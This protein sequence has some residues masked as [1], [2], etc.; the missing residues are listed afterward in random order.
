M[1]AGEGRERGKRTIVIG[2]LVIGLAGHVIAAWLNR[3]GTIAYVHH[4]GG[5]FLI[6]AVTGAVIA[7]LTWAF[8]RTQRRPA[9]LLFAS[10]QAVLG[11]L[12]AI[13]EARK[14]QAAGPHAP[15]HAGV[16]GSR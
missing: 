4:V 8:W 7:G 3:G 2:L 1:S 14:V 12:V 15:V 6:A 10:V 5:F 9:L 13:G 11:V 16:R